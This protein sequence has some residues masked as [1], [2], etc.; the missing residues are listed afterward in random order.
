MRTARSSTIVVV[1]ALLLLSACGTTEEPSSEETDPGGATQEPVTVTDARGE[2]ISLDEPATDVVALEWNGAEHAVSLGVMPVGVAD[3]EG[4]GQW[5]TTVPLDE[6]VTD[7]GVRGE[8]SMDAIV[9][10]EPDLVIA[11]SRLAPEIITQVEE[12]APVLVTEDA[13]P[14]DPIGTMTSDLQMIATATGTEDE[15]QALTDELDTALAD[16][17]QAIAEAGAEGTTFTMADGFQQGSNLVVRMYGQGSLFS[18]LATEMGLE[19]A[20]TTSGDEAYDLS[21]TDVEALTQLPDDTHFFYIISTGPDLYADGLAD[22]PIWTDLPFVQNDTVHRLPDGIWM[23]GGVRSAV[24]YI[25]A[26]VAEL[27]A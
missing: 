21:E 5:V 13:N 27:A 23:F 11:P 16:G 8:P 14:Q 4:Y 9:S 12:F 19:N 26:L 22:N 25:D 15:G 6:S 1:S 10:L 17:Q 24:Q 2:Q 7:V 18:A 3:V 20:W